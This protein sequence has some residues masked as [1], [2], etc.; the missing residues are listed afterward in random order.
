[1][2]PLIHPSVMFR[3]E[4]VVGLGGYDKA[5]RTSQDYDLWSRCS[6]RTELGQLPEV[7][8]RF[9]KH[10]GAVSSLH[11]D[12]QIDTSIRITQRNMQ[13][14]LARPVPYND[15]RAIRLAMRGAVLS[16]GQCD[17]ALDL[18]WSLL[19][20]FISR[21]QPVGDASRLI[22]RNAARRMLRIAGRRYVSH[23]AQAIRADVR[24][25]SLGYYAFRLRS[26][27]ASLLG[28]LLGDSMAAGVKRVLVRR[29]R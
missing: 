29:A 14:L 7:L 1:M 19:S 20:T 17:A 5:F 25:A 28:T 8:I 23:P 12:E 13:D 24:A 9:R 6:E 26:M 11:G 27:A 10:A 4:L 15:A 3:R 21:Y 22:R 16:R 18:V 2:N